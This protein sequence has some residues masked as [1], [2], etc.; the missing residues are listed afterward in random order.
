MLRIYNRY[1]QKKRTQKLIVALTFLKEVGSEKMSYRIPWYW[2]FPTGIRC[3]ARHPWDVLDE[4]T[5]TSDRESM[6]IVEFGPLLAFT[7]CLMNFEKLAHGSPQWTQGAQTHTSSLV[8]FSQPY[9]Y[10]PVDPTETR[11]NLQIY[12]PVISEN[13]LCH[14]WWYFQYWS[15]TLPLEVFRTHLTDLLMRFIFWYFMNR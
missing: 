13:T 15:S 2:P 5:L 9:G 12:D 8:S 14:F 7:A 3:E 6:R 4:F 1:L 10:C 11:Y